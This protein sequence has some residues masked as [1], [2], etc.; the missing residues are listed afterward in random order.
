[1]KQVSAIRFFAM[2]V[3]MFASGC[4]PRPILDRD[5]GDAYWRSGDYVLIAIDTQAQ[6]SLKV[7]RKGQW[8]V[9]DNVVAATVFAVGANDRY[10]VV[11]QHPIAEDQQHFDRA[12]TNYFIV[13]RTKQPTQHKRGEGVIGPL[14]K[15]QFDEAAKRMLLPAFTK[16]LRRLEWQKTE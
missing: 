15:E 6:M 7:D 5:F 2:L 14:T 9:F 10:I 12:V 16:T 13:D 4:G 11:K 8:A 1:M 3:V